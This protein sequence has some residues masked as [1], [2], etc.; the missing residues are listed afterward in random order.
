MRICEEGGG[1]GHEEAHADC[2]GRAH[3][4]Q[5]S[6]EEL[7]H[8]A[9]ALHVREAW[10]QRA[11]AEVAAEAAAEDEAESGDAE[12]A[13]AALAL[14]H[15]AVLENDGLLFQVLSSCDAP[16]L[17]TCG[18]VCRQWSEC[19]ASD[20]LWLP[21]CHLQR[22]DK[23]TRFR[24]GDDDAGQWRREKIRGTASFRG[25]W[26]EYLD[27]Q[28]K[29][30]RICLSEDELT[31]L[32][33]SFTF[34]RGL[35]SYAV[36]PASQSLCFAPDGK[37]S[38]HPSGLRFPWR[39]TEGGLALDIGPEDA[40]FPKASVK[41]M[42]DW[43]WRVENENVLLRE[44]GCVTGESGGAADHSAW[45]VGGISSGGDHPSDSGFAAVMVDG[46]VFYVQAGDAQ[47]IESMGAMLVG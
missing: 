35:R 20:S 16:T 33:F 43:S 30:R 10:L 19:A 18:R 31:S 25:W 2:C 17:S 14:L 41:R 13:E 28:E 9:H 5:H 1:S 39:L 40:P 11:M 47:A 38:G 34:K 3:A 24:I 4:P 8:V 32:T 21:L 6:A 37:L 42:A 23:A 26:A 44:V 7:A 12:A 45:G 36:H 29:A 22:A 27:A 46:D 15:G